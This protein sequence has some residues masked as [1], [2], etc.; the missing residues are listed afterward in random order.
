MAYEI[1]IIVDERNDKVI[2]MGTKGCPY[3]DEAEARMHTVAALNNTRNTIVDGH[4]ELQGALTIDIVVEMKDGKPEELYGFMD[5]ELAY[6]KRKALVKE[7]KD[8]HLFFDVAYDT[9]EYMQTEKE[10]LEKQDKEYQRFAAKVN[11][12]GLA[13]KPE[14]S[15]TGIDEM[16]RP[17]IFEL[18]A[19]GVE[20]YCSCQGHQG[21]PGTA[22][23][24]MDYHPRFCDY[25]LKQGWEVVVDAVIN[26]KK[27]IVNVSYLDEI[28]T[29]EER[30]R[31][32]D[33]VHKA[34]KTLI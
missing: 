26:E 30:R 24:L 17:L 1:K 31:I 4:P 22:G 5:N 32:W 16:I 3:T 14:F 29:E 19:R 20:T 34:V 28:K 11:A 25:L 27:M 8:A 13:K 10:A 23:I 12:S 15:D 2:S 21:K 33:T 6:Q 9:N 7:G 18:N